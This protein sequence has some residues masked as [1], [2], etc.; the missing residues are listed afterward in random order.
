MQEDHYSQHNEGPGRLAEKVL[1]EISEDS[2]HTSEISEQPSEFAEVR[3][4]HETK[5]RARMEEHTLAVREVARIFEES[6]LDVTERTVLNWC[7]PNKRDGS[8]RLDCY[9]DLVEKR[10]YITPQSVQAVIPKDRVGARVPKGSPLQSQLPSGAS[11]QSESFQ[12]EDAEPSADIPK[13][14]RDSIRDL[15]QKQYLL[16]V[17]SK[18]KDVAIKK[19]Q[20]MQ[21]HVYEFVAEQGKM[22]GGLEQKVRQLESPKSHHPQ[23]SADIID[24][25]PDHHYE[26]STERDE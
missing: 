4:G 22:I 9:F 17:E 15:E 1:S 20:D 12:K 11:E 5:S 26:S 16:E 3:L 24:D 14:A 18:A 21:D 7:H 13:A 25:K 6:G 2:E 19:Y 23:R 10:Y 8:Y